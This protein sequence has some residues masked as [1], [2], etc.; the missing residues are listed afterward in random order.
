MKDIGDSAFCAGLTRMVF[1]GFYTQ[2][3]PEQKPG[4]FWPHIGTHF[5]YNLTWWPMSNAWL[6]YLARC[7][8]LLQQGLFVADFAYLQD[9]AIPAFIARRPD[10]QPMRPPGFDYR[11]LPHDV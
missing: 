9:E 8:H 5:G 3:H 6:T 11:H 4:I 1:H 10:Q 7:Q 2:L